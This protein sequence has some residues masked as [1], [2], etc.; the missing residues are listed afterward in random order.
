MS[1]GAADAGGSRVGGGM[2]PDAD[3]VAFVGEDG[4][5][6]DMQTHAKIGTH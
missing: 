3:E 4:V 1:S 6:V 5:R 2:M